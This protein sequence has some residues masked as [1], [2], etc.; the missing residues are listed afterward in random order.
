MHQCFV[1]LC[2]VSTPFDEIL[3]MFLLCV[4]L[5][6][7]WGWMA[8]L[9]NPNVSR[10]QMRWGHVSSPVEFGLRYVMQNTDAVEFTMTI[11]VNHP[12]T[13]N[14]W[15]FTVSPTIPVMF[16][17]IESHRLRSPQGKLFFHHIASNTSQWPGTKC[18]QVPAKWLHGCTVAPCRKTMQ[19]KK[20]GKGSDFLFSSDQRFI[21][22][23]RMDGIYHHYQPLTIWTRIWSGK[24]QYQMEHA[25]AI[26]RLKPV[27]RNLPLVV[28]LCDSSCLTSSTMRRRSSSRCTT[29]R[30][31]GSATCTTQ[32]GFVCCFFGFFFCGY[33]FRFAVLWHI[34]VSRKLFW[35]KL[36]VCTS[37]GAPASF[38]DTRSAIE[39][40][41]MC[42][43]TTIYNYYWTII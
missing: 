5:W 38:L 22:E 42:E 27:I 16:C 40:V 4:T 15:C 28:L 6:G 12:F 29:T 13:V 26:S 14:Q 21:W 43:I 37:A 11:T 24:F 20:D 9:D 10:S 31:S 41:K 23:N 7:W 2:P 3:S 33:D 30:C 1:Q 36:L 18:L 32:H 35:L 39:N 34:A 25:A 17:P 8:W 19:N